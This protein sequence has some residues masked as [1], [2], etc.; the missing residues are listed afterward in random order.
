MISRQKKILAF[1]Q[2]SCEGVFYSLEHN[3]SKKTH[4]K[5]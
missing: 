5:S 1:W 2:D 3:L 4:S